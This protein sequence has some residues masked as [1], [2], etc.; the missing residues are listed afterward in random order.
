MLRLSACLRLAEF[1]ERSRAGRV[2]DLSVEIDKKSVRIKLQARE[3]PHVEMREASKQAGL[4]KRAF[5]R[6]MILESD[7]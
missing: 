5:G 3:D 4:F 7:T 6:E 1:L 2:K